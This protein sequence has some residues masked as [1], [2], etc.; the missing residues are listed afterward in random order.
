MG[1]NDRSENGADVRGEG[2]GG[3]AG[4][5]GA[6]DRPTDDG[7]VRPCAD[8]VGRL[9]ALGSHSGGE[10]LL[11]LSYHGSDRPDPIRSGRGGDEAVHSTPSL[12]ISSACCAVNMT[13]PGWLISVTA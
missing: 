7:V 1:F 10:D 13:A 2:L 12:A 5:V 6:V 4:V 3:C 8:G 9:P 11:P